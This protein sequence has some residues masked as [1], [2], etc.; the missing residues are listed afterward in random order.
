MNDHSQKLLFSHFLSSFLSMSTALGHSSG[1]LLISHS[2]R[3]CM[4]CWICIR[5]LASAERKELREW[6]EVEDKRVT[7]LINDCTQQ[8]TTFPISSAYITI[9]KGRDISST[10]LMWNPKPH[11]I[12]L[13]ISNTHPPLPSREIQIT[14]LCFYLSSYF[15]RTLLVPDME[16]LHL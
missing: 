13:S 15:F 11:P 9:R 2:P 1:F 16:S 8:S 3:G 4:I 12:V 5:C 10:S 14:Q 7:T 6:W